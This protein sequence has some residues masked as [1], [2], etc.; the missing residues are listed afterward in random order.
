MTLD[1]LTYTAADGGTRFSRQALIEGQNMLDRLAGQRSQSQWST[2]A[3]LEVGFGSS[4]RLF[5]LL[6]LPVLEP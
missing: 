2:V 6:S 3:Q 1:T 4:S 5:S